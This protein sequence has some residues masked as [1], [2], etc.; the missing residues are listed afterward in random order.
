LSRVRDAMG[1]RSIAYDQNGR[2]AKL[3]WELSAA[4]ARVTPAVAATYSMALSY[5]SLGALRSADLRG[6]AVAATLTY[7][8]DDKGRTRSIASSGGQ[9]VAGV[10]YDAEDRVLEAAYGNGTYGQWVFNEA[11]GK[12]DMVRYEKAE[13]SASLGYV[14][15]GYDANRNPVLETRI[16]EDGRPLGTK[17]H[18]FDALDRLATTSHVDL[19]GVKTE[20]V[21]GYSP[22]GNIRNAG[23]ATY[24]YER[25]DMPQAATRVVDTVTG[26]RVLAYDAR[27]TLVGDGARA[28]GYDASGCLANVRGGGVNADYVCSGEGEIVARRVTDSTGR[29]LQAVVNLGDIAE[30]R[31]LTTLKI[32]RNLNVRFLWLSDLPAEV[33]VA[34][35]SPVSRG[36]SLRSSAAPPLTRAPLSAV[37]ANTRF[38]ATSAPSKPFTHTTLSEPYA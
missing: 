38:K 13:D 3:T 16:G 23:T 11:T 2:E 12:V 30:V 37:S 22:A 7:G 20:S 1:E 19:R 36:H 32:R 9:L 31:V 18:T 28:L 5:D 35:C 17:A 8:H 33:S 24:A 14:R 29:V 15:Y 6:G 34:E 21:F 4:A 26:T 25:A 27:G 10:Q